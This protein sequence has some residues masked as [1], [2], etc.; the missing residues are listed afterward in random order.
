MLS[1][2]GSPTV[3]SR[4][5]GRHSN[6][7][8]ANMGGGIGTSVSKKRGVD[9]REVALG[10]V[11]QQ[12][13]V[14]DANTTDTFIEAAR[15]VFDVLPDT[16]TPGEVQMKMME[17]AFGIDA[18]RGV[19]WP[20]INPALYMEVGINWNI[21]PN[22]VILP[23]VTFCLG[24]RARPDGLNPDS[25]I[26]EV[27]NLERFPEGEEPKPENTFIEELTAEKWG[28]LFEQDF[29]NMPYVQKGMKADGAVLRP[30]PYWES[31]VI[32]FRHALAGYMGNGGPETSGT[33]E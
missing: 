26:F 1:R 14:C 21:F 18:E 29:Q 27:F 28:L 5:Q 15:R 4:A 33:E 7:G 6:I 19:K 12:K 2:W 32:N 25:C 31:S 22:T 16:A 20:R 23:N 13:Q 30:N 24:F 17:I 9:A 11:T 8:V 10:M 3:W